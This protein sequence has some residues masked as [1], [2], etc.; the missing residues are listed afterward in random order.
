MQ[1]YC[2]QSVIFQSMQRL[3]GG[4]QKM[5]CPT[6]NHG[7]CSQY[8]KH[9]RKMCYMGHR[10]FLPPDYPFQRD[11]KSFDG[12]EDQRSAPTPLSG[13][14]VLE[15]VR[16]IN[17]VFGKGQNKKCQDNEGTWKKRSIFLNFHTGNIKN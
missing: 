15:D 14:E 11:K 16:G 7:T 12:K 3:L 8:L 4:A 6:C 9:S 1:P 5:E 2:G 13:T 10:A 17:N